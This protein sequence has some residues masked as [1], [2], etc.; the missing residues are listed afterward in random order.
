MRELMETG[1]LAEKDHIQKLSKP[2]FEK[3]IKKCCCC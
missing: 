2:G 3:K 1:K